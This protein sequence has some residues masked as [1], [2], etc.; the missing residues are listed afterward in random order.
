MPATMNISLPEPLKKFVDNQ[1]RKAGYAGASDYVRELIRDHRKRVAA[2][3]LRGL[4]AEGLASGAP[5]P[6]DKHYWTAKR[7]QLGA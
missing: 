6:A 2:D 4:I 5:K 1:V 3:D 7:K